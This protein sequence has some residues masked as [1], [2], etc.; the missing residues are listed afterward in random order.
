MYTVVLKRK[1]RMWRVNEVT[2]DQWPRSRRVVRARA[3]VPPLCLSLSL[4]QVLPRVAKDEAW[5]EAERSRRGGGDKQDFSS[6]AYL[7]DP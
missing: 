4:A 7:S 2:W 5:D 6:C 3:A 1:Q